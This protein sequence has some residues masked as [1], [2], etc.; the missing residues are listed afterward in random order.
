MEKSFKCWGFS[1]VNMFGWRVLNNGIPVRASRARKG[2]NVDVTFPMCGDA[3]ED[4]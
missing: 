1:K 4:I 3:M 2:M